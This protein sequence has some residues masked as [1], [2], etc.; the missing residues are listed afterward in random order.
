VESAFLAMTDQERDVDARFHLSLLRAE[1]GH[2]PGAVA[3]LDSIVAVA[4]NHLFADYLKALIAD[5]QG[6]AA[7]GR[8]ARLDFR[9]HF[10]AEVALNRPEYLAHR[11]LLDDFLRTTPTN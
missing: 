7:A 8:A 1:V 3:Q 10:A 6:N 2:F 11:S 4:P 9:R 5:F